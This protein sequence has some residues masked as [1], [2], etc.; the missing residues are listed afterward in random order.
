MDNPKPLDLESLSVMYPTAE[1]A[2]ACKAYFEG[3]AVMPKQ[4]E[5]FMS[6]IHG[7]YVAFS[8][9]LRNGSGE[10]RE[11]IAQAFGDEFTDQEKAE[12]A[13]LV[14]YPADKMAL[15]EETFATEE[16]RSQWYH[17][18]IERITQLVRV[19]L[20][21]KNVHDVSAVLPEGF[22]FILQT[23]I[24][25]QNDTPVHARYRQAVIASLI[26]TGMA[27]L[28]IY[29]LAKVVQVLMVNH[30]HMLG[31]VYDR[32]PAPQAIMEELMDFHSV[33]V[34]WGNHDI[35]WMGAALG[36]RGC[37][38]HVVR[39]CA[40]YGNLSILEDAY[41]IN[42]DPLREFAL[43]TYH[44][45]PCDSFQL[46][47]DPGLDPVELEANIK[48]QKAM[49]ILQFKV[50]AALIKEYPCFELE[51]RLLLDKIDYDNKTVEVDGVVY[52]VTDTYF[53]TVDKVD[54]YMLTPEEESVMTYL[55]NAFKGSEL[56]QRHMGFFLDKGSLYKVYNNNLLL[57]ACVPLNPDGTFK[58]ANIFGVRYKGKALFDIC[59][60]YV[61]LAFFSRDP[62]ER[63]RGADLI[64]YLWLGQ[65]SPLFAKS[66]MATFEIYLVADKAARKEEKNA[67][68]TL[69]NDEAVI[70]RIFTEFGITSE[71]GHIICGHVPVKAKDGEDPV[72]G[73]G[74]VLTID[75]GFSSAYQKTT[76]LAG[77]TL[78]FAPNALMLDAQK[79]LAS[80]DEA[81]DHNADIFAQRRVLETY[82]PVITKGKTQE[83][84]GYLAAALEGIDA[85]MHAYETG[86][87]EEKEIQEG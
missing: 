69:L 43:S 37:I 79:P 3:D 67:F 49:A 85:L 30:L 60:H 17:D 62:M 64:W 76:G 63:R 42:L 15:I 26:E 31:D 5:F 86:L 9:I 82:D 25:T 23:L 71:R 28:V 22:G 35:V 12:F 84:G 70:E 1:V 6:D 61:K 4:T 73:G 47:E 45:D 38:A 78:I 81:I 39:N 14:C 41:G 20:R 29:Y 59:Q 19:A 83:Q 40:R 50:E 10:L 55:E 2:A 75:G 87:L 66:K 18:T 44:D 74:K 27:Q 56:L 33:D 77:Y 16:S 54:P 58:E 51:D 48:I 24:T 21:D 11:L 13:T 8:H 46:K 57:H 68:Y 72:K 80:L 53:P 36:Q 7:E 65:A 32:G 52:G 34:Q